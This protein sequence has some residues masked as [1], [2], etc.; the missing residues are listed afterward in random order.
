MRS[1]R[2]TRNTSVQYSELSPRRLPSSKL[3]RLEGVAMDSCTLVVGPSQQY[4]GRSELYLDQ[5][6]CKPGTVLAYYTG[7]VLTEAEKDASESRYIFEVPT[8]PD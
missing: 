2:S 5:K 7:R 4:E 1:T 6:S 3:R 8:G